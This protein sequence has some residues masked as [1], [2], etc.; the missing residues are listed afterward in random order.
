MGPMSAEG[1]EQKMVMDSVHCVTYGKSA[2][3]GIRGYEFA[4]PPTHPCRSTTTTHMVWPS[5]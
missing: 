3:P 5:G 2:P 1:D 4:E